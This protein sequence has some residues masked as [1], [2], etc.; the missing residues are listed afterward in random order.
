MSCGCLASQ[1]HCL[2]NTSN[3]NQEPRRGWHEQTRRLGTS[4]SGRKLALR[5]GERRSAEVPHR[6]EGWFEPFL[7][8]LVHL[9]R[10]G[11]QVDACRITWPLTGLDVVVLGNNRVFR[12]I[13]EFPRGCRRQTQ[14]ASA[15]HG[16]LFPSSKTSKNRASGKPHLRRRSAKFW[17]PLLVFTILGRTE[18]GIGAGVRIL[19]EFHF[20]LLVSGDRYHRECIQVP[21]RP[22]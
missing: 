10:S 9:S 11:R 19:R 14:A 1:A 4:S 22:E 12:T 8:S 2:P 5:R 15:A 21:F 17:D 6:H 16:F 18:T 7:V 13:L 3:H 20:K